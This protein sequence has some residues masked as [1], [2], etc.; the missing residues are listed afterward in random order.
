MKL[1]WKGPATVVEVYPAREPKDGKP[2]E[3]LFSGAVVPDREFEV[4]GA[5]EDHP[6]I[7]SWRAFGLI[8]DAP[9][10]TASEPA[11]PEPAE[12]APTGRR[13]KKSEEA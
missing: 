10:P 9:A 11:A 6:Q 4:E 3:P 7:T 2:L 8:A 12:P 13:T 1:I 5:A